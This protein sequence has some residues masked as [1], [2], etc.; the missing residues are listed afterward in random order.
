MCCLRLP[1]HIT[2][3][4]NSDLMCKSLFLMSS[5]LCHPMSVNKLARIP[6]IFWDLVVIDA[7]AG[8]LHSPPCSINKKGLVFFTVDRIFPFSAPHRDGLDLYS[9]DGCVRAPRLAPYCCIKK[10]FNKN[11]PYW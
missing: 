9:F 2:I 7:V 8:M 4:S 1:M 5:R 6:L 11:S 10:N 3:G